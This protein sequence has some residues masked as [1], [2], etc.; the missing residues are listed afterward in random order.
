MNGAVRTRSSRASAPP[1]EARLAALDWELIGAHLDADGCALIGPVLSDEECRALA[2]T[3]DDDQR[4][5]SRIVMARHGF[6]RGE[7]K[8]FTHPLPDLVA[9]LRTA[10]YSRLAGIANRWNEALGTSETL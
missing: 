7:Y 2:A 1:V 5:R 10:L 6:G 8:Y 9:S 3:Y 4:F